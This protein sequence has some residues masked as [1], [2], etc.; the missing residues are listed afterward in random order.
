[1]KRR[2][3]VPL[4]ALLL[5]APAAC[6][7]GSP[8]NVDGDPG[9]SNGADPGEGGG[10]E[11]GTTVPDCPLTA[12]EISA[13]VARSLTDRGGCSFGDG[14]ALLSITTA[15]QSAALMTYD[16]QRTLAAETYDTVSDLQREGTGFFAVKDIEAQLVLIRSDGAYT[17]TMSSFSLDAAQYEQTMYQLVDAIV[18]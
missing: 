2:W 4:M 15:S 16:Y 10:T 12:D 13:I 9:V 5:V 6:G 3:T 11:A 8:T 18:A 1:M 7:S 17:V 14:I